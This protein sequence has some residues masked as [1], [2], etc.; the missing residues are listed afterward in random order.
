[1]NPA[2]AERKQA[3]LQEIQALKRERKAVILAHLYE[4]IE[5]QDVADFRG[6]SLGLSR[7]AAD[8][9]AEVIVFCGV[10]FMAETAKLL[11]PQKTVY[12]ANPHAGCPMADMITAPELIAFKAEH[13]GV[14]V[15]AYVNTS[16]EVK[17]DDE[18]ELIVEE[19]GELPFACLPI[20]GVDARIED[21]DEDLTG[22]RSGH[23]QVGKVQHLGPAKAVNR[24]CTHSRPCLDID[25]RHYG[26]WP[27]RNV[28]VPHLLALAND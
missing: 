3:L 18:R 16:A 11:S 19:C 10:H 12:L 22:A 13:P 5:V 21:L 24:H 8:T 25:V 6:D 28:S 2:A 17:A 1:M 20:G 4:R 14:P 7:L 27:L 23:G 9:D 26:Y 15:V